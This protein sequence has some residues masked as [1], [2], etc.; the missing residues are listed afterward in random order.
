VIVGDVPA[1]WAFR[2][3]TD[4]EHITHE[5][6]YACQ[7]SR[8]SIAKAH[9]AQR[10]HNRRRSAPSTAPVVMQGLS[11]KAGKPVFSQSRSQEIANNAGT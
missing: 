10:E 7:T 2:Q 3:Y 4:L 8:T 11:K 6:W 1:D 5:F 9:G